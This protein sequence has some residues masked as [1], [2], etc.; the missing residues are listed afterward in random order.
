[1]YL[2]KNQDKYSFNLSS[3]DFMLWSGLGYK[4]YTTAFDE[5][6]TEGYLVLEN[7]MKSTYVFYDKSRKPPKEEDIT[8]DIP[9]EKVK[10]I[11]EAAAIIAEVR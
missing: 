2:A 9:E 10:E 4:A 1:M 6:I 8:V 3:N 7:G 5:L 11:R